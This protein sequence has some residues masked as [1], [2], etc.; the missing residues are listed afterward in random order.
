[1]KQATPK[2]EELFSAALELDSPEAR[3]AFL[4]RACGDTELRR[5]VEQ[6]LAA[7]PEASYFLEAPAPMPAV[8]AACDPR[9]VLEEPGT[10]IGPYRLMEQIGEGGMGVVFVAEQHQPVRRKVAL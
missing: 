5:R 10:V 1:M 3:S 4:D 7:A 2:L 6:L 8:T 9:P